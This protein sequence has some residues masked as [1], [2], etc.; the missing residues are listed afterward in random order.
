MWTLWIV[1]FNSPISVPLQAGRFAFATFD[2]FRMDESSH[3]D[4]SPPK[5]KCSLILREGRTLPL[6]GV[7]I[8][9]SLRLTCLRI[10]SAV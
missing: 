8:C 9:G 3:K 6:L 4:N 1:T 7:P 2:D 10:F 5:V